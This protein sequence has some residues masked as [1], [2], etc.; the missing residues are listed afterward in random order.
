MREIVSRVRIPLSPP[1]RV[2]CYAILC[3][4]LRLSLDSLDENSSRYFT[5]NHV[6]LWTKLWTG[7]KMYKLKNKELI[8]LTKRKHH[9]GGGLYVRI[10]RNEKDYGPIDIVLIKH[11]MKYF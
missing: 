9:D 8:Y 6:P 1:S 11:L 10:T 3:H 5:I 4:N 7:G 2:L